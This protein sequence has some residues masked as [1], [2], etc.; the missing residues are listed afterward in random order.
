[1]TSKPF[2]I[3]VTGASASGKTHLV[4]E[5]AD[6]VGASKVCIF[7]QDNYYLPLKQ[8]QKDSFGKY[9]FDLPTALDLKAF[10]SDL[11]NLIDGSKVILTEYTY[12]HPRKRAKTLTFVSKPVIIIEGLFLLDYPLVEKSIDYLVY[13]ESPQDL[14]LE[15]RLERDQIKRKISKE[16]ILHQWEHHVNPTLEGFRKIKEKA[17]LVLTNKDGIPGGFDDLKDVVMR[18]LLHHVTMNTSFMS[19]LP[20]RGFIRR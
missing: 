13:V 10:S 16:E 11:F 4:K 12:N 5:L 7:P 9:N 17:D 15:R 6:E 18:K 3:G 2:I 19:G 1:M 14:K 20:G 8:Q